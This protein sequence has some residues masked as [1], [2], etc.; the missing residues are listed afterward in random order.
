MPSERR[1]AAIAQKP[2]YPNTI[3]RYVEGL[4]CVQ[5]RV[6]T[7]A[8]DLL[9]MI[10]TAGVLVERSVLREV[11]D[12]I[13]YFWVRA[14]HYGPEVADQIKGRLD[15]LGGHMTARFDVHLLLGILVGG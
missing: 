11:L 13:D 4:R 5:D 8:A 2:A 12:L 9:S 15:K 1:L 10:A 14:E 6:W 7:N 3:G